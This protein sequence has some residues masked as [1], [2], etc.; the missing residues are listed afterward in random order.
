[1]TEKISK[2]SFIAMMGA[3]AAGAGLSGQLSAQEAGTTWDVIVIG[4][5]N[6]GLPTA[7]FAGQRGAR[8]LIIEA[9]AALGGTLFMSSGQMSAA[10]TKL[11]KQKG[12][13]DAPQ[14]HYDD[15]MRISKNTANPEMV[16]LAVFNA[17]ETFDWLMDNGL[18]VHPQHPETG[19]THE[20][21][22]RARYAWGKQGGRSILAV[23][24]SQLKP[25]LDSGKVTALTSTSAKELI[26]DASGAVIGVV[27]QDASGKTTRHMGKNVVLT[28]GGYTASTE[29]YEKY[30]G[31]KR[32]SDCT[33]PYSKG[34]GLTMGIKAGGYARGAEHHLPLF[35]AVMASDNYPSPF[36]GTHRPWPPNQPPWGIYVNKQGKRFLCED[37][38]SHDAFEQ[39]LLKQSDERCWLVVDDA[40]LNQMPPFVGRM[41]REQL[42]EAFGTRPMFFKGDTLEAL[43]KAA[44]IDGKALVSTVSEYN[45]GQKSGKDAL[46]RKHMPLPLAKGPYYAVQLQSWMLMSFAG[47]AV[48]KDLQVI[49]KNGTAIPNLYAAGELLGAGLLHG[50]SYC[51]GMG[52]TPCL[53]FGRLLGQ[54]ILKFA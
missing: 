43:A 30:E 36:I 15:I 47:L 27:A 32:Y 31:V 6:S 19:T 20:P 45:A 10:G 34:D 46:G 24:N 5:G 7:I 40:M 53:T 41:T 48:N 38:A 28:V 25:L 1:M 50:R 11:Q 14:L 12:I 44:G 2:R 3:A 54:K 9:A 22:S 18:D 23:L 4:G 17:A 49:R 37:V 52:V 33:Y 51:G 29:M 21:Y 16:R 8:V 42:K 26:Q 13:E 39:A 35:G